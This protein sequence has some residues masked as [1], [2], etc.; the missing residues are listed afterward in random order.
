MANVKS[1]IFTLTLLSALLVG[2]RANAKSVDQP[3]PPPPVVLLVGI[4]PGTGQA[5]LWDEGDRAYRIVKV[6][7]EVRG[8][9][10][11]SITE[12][13][14]VVSQG[15]MSLAVPLTPSP[16][17]LQKYARKKSKQGPF[18]VII[19]PKQYT[20]PPSFLGSQPAA[21]APSALLKDVP[22]P[23]PAGPAL[24]S[25][26]ESRTASSAEQPK[27]EEQKFE[28]FN[29]QVL[30]EPPPLPAEPL[31]ISL[32]LLRNE[33]S[34]FL[35]KRAGYSAVLSPADGILL[36][37]VAEGSLPHRLGLRSG[38]RLISLGGKALKDK[39]A[40]AD[41]YLSLLPGNEVKLVVLRK[42]GKKQTL[43]LRVHG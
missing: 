35:G 12:D 40:A 8:A 15:E 3:K 39:D 30:E 37:G 5:I 14:I 29:E 13:R 31:V 36:D 21:P 19:A 23:M 22:V 27:V 26:P 24:A 9:K 1:G 42:S 43:R 16:F 18:P 41:A 11:V 25:Y 28:K 10:V 38:D 2:S 33:V 7:E 6:G 4:V 32:K 17:F 34:S 20:S